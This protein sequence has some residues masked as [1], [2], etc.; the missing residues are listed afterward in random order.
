VKASKPSPTAKA[1]AATAAAAEDAG[2]PQPWYVDTPRP[3]LT[4][5]E[6][7]A[8]R[9]TYEKR[10]ISY[11]KDVYF[12]KEGKRTPLTEDQILAVTEK[13]ISITRVD[14]QN[15]VM[16]AIP[17][18]AR[19][20]TVTKESLCKK[21]KNRYVSN[22]TDYYFLDSTCVAHLFPNWDTFDLH[23]RS[24]PALGKLH[25]LPAKDM[26]KLPVGDPIPSMSDKLSS[27]K[28]T[29]APSLIP[30]EKA[31]KGLIGRYMSYQYQVYRIEKAGKEGECQRVEVEGDALTRKNPDIRIQELEHSQAYSIPLGK[32]PMAK[33]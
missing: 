22:G 19:V 31:C 25:I 13:G 21:Y 11:Y 14:S 10:Y 1:E 15:A 30:L 7:A 9:K 5:A 27:L 28:M 32:K 18:A 3:F 16:E 23:E 26:E 33:K 29:P 24:H 2:P 6:K 4:E 20:D 12:V 8:I 17:L